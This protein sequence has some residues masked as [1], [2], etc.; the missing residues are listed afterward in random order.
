MMRSTPALRSAVASFSLIFLMSYAASAASWTLEEGSR[1]GFK[2]SQGGAP[3]EGLFEAFDAEI[4]FFVEDLE[5]SR[6]VVVIDVASV[7]SE[8]KDRDDAIR[9]PS[10]FNVATW[11][12]A[13]FETKAFRRIAEDRFEAV[14]ELTMRDVT[15][16]VILPF[17]LE[18][19]PHPEKEG[20][21][22]A[23]ARAELAVMRLDY[24]IGQGRWQDTSV[25][26]N[27]VVIFMEIIAS[28]PAG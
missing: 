12:A 3:V 7:N 13:R 11:P 17:M 18:I 6:V 15:K 14:A 4:D 2:T 1:L 28:R 26:P 16:E 27:E 21:L 5:T 10:L 9:S 20:H 23:I 24:G 19:E 22:R 25:V 8:S